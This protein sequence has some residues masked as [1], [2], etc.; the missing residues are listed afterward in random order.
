[1]VLFFSAP[2]AAR[3]LDY[4]CSDF[5]NQAEAQA[6]LLPG[7][8]YGLDGDNDGVAC[9]SPPLSVLVRITCAGSD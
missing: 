5:A 4:N 6:H 3:A 9:K 2:P 7:D 1:M 8:P